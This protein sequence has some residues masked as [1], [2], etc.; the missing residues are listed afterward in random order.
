MYMLDTNICSYIIKRHPLN[1]LEK[2][3]TL[4]KQQ[5]C[6]SIITYAELHYGVEKSSSKKLNQ[7]VIEQFI[8]RLSVVPWDMDA[9]L[10]YTKIRS[11]LEKQ[12]TPIEN[13]D[14]LIAAHARSQNLILVTNNLREF[15]RV[16]DLNLENWTPS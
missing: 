3:E 10:H 16:P 4:Q 1:V 12:G 7:E 2:F 15:E 9:A 8:K 13:M 11:Y 5:L 6:I 14:L